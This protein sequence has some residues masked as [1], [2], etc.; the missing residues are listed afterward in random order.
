MPTNVKENGRG[1]PGCRKQT[2][3]DVLA[4]AGS[5]LLKCSL[6]SPL[7]GYMDEQQ[8]KRI[9]DEFHS[10]CYFTVVWCRKDLI[11][12]AKSTCSGEGGS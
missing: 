8:Q 3:H 6:L 9:S 1:S 10:S 11:G 5:S 7:L 4:G 2:H 12:K